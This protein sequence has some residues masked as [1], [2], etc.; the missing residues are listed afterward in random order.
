MTQGASWLALGMLL[1]AL[2]LAFIRLLRGPT[3]PDRVIALDF[4]ATLG[5]GIS[6][7]YALAVQNPVF[8]DIAVLLALIS[9]LSTIAFAQY[10]R[11]RGTP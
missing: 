4:M 2:F 11:K 9:F 5:V 6:A 8:L 1:L 7:V 10:V 3:L